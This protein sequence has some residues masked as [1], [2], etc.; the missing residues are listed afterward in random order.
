M[1]RF[2]V[3]A[4]AA[5]SSVTSR[6]SPPS[7]KPPKP[8][9]NSF[10]IDSARGR[11]RLARGWELS[12]LLEAELAKPLRRKSPSTCKRNHERSCKNR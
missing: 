5:R 8:P 11:S 2:A 3:F 12:S 1:K 10:S 4:F 7:T 6:W 9:R